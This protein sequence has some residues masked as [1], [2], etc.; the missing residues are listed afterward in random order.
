VCMGSGYYHKIAT[1]GPT[2]KMEK[3]M[4]EFSGLDLPHDYD[5]YHKGDKN[6]RGWLGQPTGTPVRYEGHLGPALYKFDKDAALPE[7]KTADSR[8]QAAAPERFGETGLCFRVEKTGPF[9]AGERFT[10]VASLPVSGVA[11]EEQAEYT[12]SFRVRASSMYGH[13][14]PRYC[15][16]PRNIIVRLCVDGRTAGDSAERVQ[17]QQGYREEFLVFEDERPVSLT[18]MAPTNG[19]GV[20]E[21]CL[22]EAAGTIELRDLKIQKG[23]GDVLYRPFENGLVVLNGS[24]FSPVD[25]PVKELFPDGAFRR[26]KGEQ[27]PSHNNGEPVGDVLTVQPLDAYLLARK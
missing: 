20:L 16:I 4:K 19:E 11:F 1:R 13:V 24:H 17:K 27:D 21:I 9:T 12:L 10:L 22:S 18:I 5:E 14:D 15:P 7:I 23:C 25:F 3:Q 8:W 26:L 2:T 6:M